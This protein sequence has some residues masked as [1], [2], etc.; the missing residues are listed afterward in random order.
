MKQIHF[1]H[2]INQVLPEK[3]MKE[4]AATYDVQDGP[5]DQGEMYT[6]P[7]II[8]DQSRCQPYA[9][10]KHQRITERASKEG[11]SQWFKKIRILYVHIRAPGLEVERMFASISC[12]GAVTV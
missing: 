11:L 3:R 8:T 4:I 6:R 1:R 7:A 12:D 10:E 5:N 9:L 2:L